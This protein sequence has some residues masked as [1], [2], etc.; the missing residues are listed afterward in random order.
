MVE[1]IVPH[2]GANSM[3]PLRL[4]FVQNCTKKGGNISS[5]VNCIGIIV[6]RPVRMSLIFS[7]HKMLKG[8]SGAVFSECSI[9]I[10]AVG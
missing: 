10:R 2:R 5:F 4:V 7:N 9:E 1:I 6:G 3:R 8:K